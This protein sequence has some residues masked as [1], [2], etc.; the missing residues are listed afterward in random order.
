[1][2][3][4]EKFSENHPDNIRIENDILKL[5]LKAQYGDAFIMESNGGLPPE[6]ENLFLKNILAFEKNSENAEF[7]TVYEKIGKPTYKP[8]NRLKP[9]E[10]T[11]ALKK[12]TALMEQQGVC[13]DICQGPYPDDVIY[14]FITE[15]LFSQ[16]VQ[17]EPLLGGVWHFIYEEFHPNDKRDIEKNTHEFLLHWFSRDINEF[18][19]ALGYEIFTADAR[20]LSRDAVIKKINLFFDAFETFKDDGYTID[21][22][23]FEFPEPEHGLGHAEGMLKYDAVME[24]GEIL[25]YEG[26]YK[27]YMQRR[28]NYWTIFY[29]VMP[30][31][32]W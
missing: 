28:D 20:R 12:I 21:E 29:F 16:E 23:H 4:E 7:I 9:A 17:A 1:M 14:R 13:L 25:H 31:F 22:I 10:I 26:P 3:P 2:L 30:G 5:T 18:S 8:A 24:N 19:T 27:L 32:V 11:A 6:M 15:E